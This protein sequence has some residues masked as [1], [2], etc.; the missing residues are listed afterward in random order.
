MFCITHVL[1]IYRHFVSPTQQ[2]LKIPYSADNAYS[3]THVTYVVVSPP[4]KEY[5]L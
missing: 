1:H 3:Y 5:M 2:Y 4:F